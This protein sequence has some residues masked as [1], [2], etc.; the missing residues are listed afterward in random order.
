ML[1]MTVE[2]GGTTNLVVLTGDLDCEGAA[3]LT[4]CVSDLSFGPAARDVILDMSGVEFTDS[5]GLDA[6]VWCQ[7]RC[8]AE[9]VAFC[10]RNPSPLL[11]R[12]LV[13][14]GDASKLTIERAVPTPGPSDLIEPSGVGVDLVADTRDSIA[15]RR[16]DRADERDRVADARDLE[17]DAHSSAVEAI[18]A[19]AVRRE[20]EAERR[21][22]LA[23]ARDAD[24]L[25]RPGRMEAD[26]HD[27][28]IGAID[29]LHSGHDRDASAEDRDDLA[30]IWR[31]ER[32]AAQGRTAAAVQRA[33]DG[34]ARDEAVLARTRA[35][36]DDE[37]M[38]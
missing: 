26:K 37:Q 2:A 36:M 8:T 7:K 16:D 5:S 13:I 28:Q 25:L 22:R 27:A 14:T 12:I 9:G 30:T 33:A 6:L 1:T 10:V 17:A 15:D 24:A 18:M 23:E 34:V 11:G 4:E 31:S 38:I 32:G 29:R 21:D 3:R 19:A 35:S 20:A